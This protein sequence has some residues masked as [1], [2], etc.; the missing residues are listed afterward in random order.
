MFL[1][2]GSTVRLG[3]PFRLLWTAVTVSSFGDGMRFVALPLLAAQVSDDPR[4]VAFVS[5]AEQLPWLLTGLVAGALADR[6]DRRR[7]LWTIDSGRALAAGLLAVAITTGLASI[8]LLAAAGFALGCGQTLYSGAWSAIV[9]AVVGT[10]R[11]T[12]ANARL[13][14]GSVVSDALL[15]TPLGALLFA[16]AAAAP[17]VVDAASFAI[18]AALVALLPGSFRPRRHGPHAEGAGLFAEVSEGL[19][20][21]W[22][23]PLLR[24]LCILGGISE[25]VAMGLIAILV[26]YARRVLGLDAAG[27]GLLIAAFAV[28]GLAGAS[29]TARLTARLGAGWAVRLAIFGSATAAACAGAT[30]APLVAAASV[31]GYGVA[32][33][34]WSITT[35]S[36]RQAIVPSGLLGRVTMAYQIVGYGAAALGAAGAGLLAHE[37][38]LRTPFL[39]GAA[40]LA[41]AGLASGRALRGAPR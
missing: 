34:V 32:S 27:Y 33:L 13:Q 26:L 21:L 6:L 16:L 22:R 20:W 11:L 3:G 14:A 37:Y 41:T 5:L 25:F 28:G 4:A 1:A 38:G 18:A 17:F 31:A 40:V 12:S 30:S 7:M 2:S 15:G 8:P 39:V 9:P 35:V 24:T 10:H 36:L 23:Q 29:V 19:R